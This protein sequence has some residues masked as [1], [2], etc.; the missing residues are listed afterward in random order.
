M[1]E[2]DP[3]PN[4][5]PGLVNAE[6]ANNYY[7]AAMP[8]DER[9]NSIVNR[10]DYNLSE[11]HR[12]FG[13]WYWNHRL[14]NEYDWM[15][16]TK[17][18]IMANGLTRINK[19][20]GADY[21][22]TVS[23]TT[24]VNIGANWT[25][26]NEGAVNSVLTSYKASDVGLPAYIDAKAGAYNV[27]PRI[28]FGSTAIETASQ[29]YP[30]ITTRGT[31]G[32]AKIALNQIL[33]DHSLKY[34]Y[35]ERRYWYTGANPGYPAGTFDFNNNYLK[36]AD[37]TTTASN[38]G[39]AWAAFMMGLP[40]SM[41]IDSNDTSLFSTRYRAL[42]VQDDW[43]VSNKLRLNLGLRYDY[44]AWPVDRYN[45]ISNF[46]PYARNPQNQLMGRMEYAGIDFG[47]G[48]RTADRNNWG[49]RAGF[50]LDL[51]GRNQTV[52]RGGYSVFYP[53]IVNTAYFGSTA[54]FA[55]V[56]TQYQPDGNNTNFP[57]FRF[58]DGLPSP[59][60]APLGAGL[61]PSGFLGQAVSHEE[62]TSQVPMSQQWGLSLQHRLKAWRLEL[63]YSANR[64][65]HMAA[66]NYDVNQLDPQYLS[67]GL[68]LQDQ[69]PNP[70]RGLVPG[71]LGNANI[72]RSQSLR[73]FPYYTN[74][75][76]LAPTLGSSAYH[77]M[78]VSVERRLSNGLG[79]LLSYTNGKLLSDSIRTTAIGTE[80]G[81]NS[82][83]QNG[84]YNRAA[85]WSIDP[86]DVS[87]RIVVSALYE[88]PFGRGRRWSTSN[89]F[90]DQV[91]RGWQLNIINTMQ[92]GNPLSVGGA[93]NFLA[94]RPNS[95]G[96]SAKL[97]DRTPARWFDT[98]R[99]VNPPNFTFGNIGRTLPDVRGPATINFDFSATKYMTLRERLRLQ[100]RG[101]AFNVFNH[102]NYRNP[103]VSFQPGAAGTNISGNFGV[104]TA[105]RDARIM[106]VALK[107]I[108]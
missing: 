95:T 47:R 26:F 102:V 14:A 20:I 85:E 90:L 58:R 84:K 13:R 98:T 3:K 27:L 69:V 24:I 52:L 44:Q 2:S 9:F 77:A 68:A 78:L 16:E 86:T 12:V 54:G 34:G 53:Q 7:A 45:G 66:S 62:T 108:F 60:I 40:S 42:Y 18:G 73:P 65:T 103:N 59:P 74:V 56:T 91:I 48:V 10:V 49:P 41:S 82:G 6:G 19:G 39:L 93:N 22:W 105:A 96:V 100:L 25:R 87:Q 71:S 75:N 30:A 36:A 67:L 61:G 92:T 15:Y 37:D 43:R 29:S 5:V 28:T 33:G 64:V 31:T 17:K 55:T 57:A 104:I 89:T 81:G 50:A 38:T 51:T 46:D 79:V 106:Q 1:D 83:Y 101:E 21:V 35:M 11:K 70:Y 23:G 76:V 99:F 94:D 97:E 8:K 80:V 72:T 107:L 4:D 32:E 63:S 88:L